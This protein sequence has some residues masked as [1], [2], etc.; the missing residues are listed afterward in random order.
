M[1]DIG[2]V[3]VGSVVKSVAYGGRGSYVKKLWRR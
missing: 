3:G 2:N 1:C